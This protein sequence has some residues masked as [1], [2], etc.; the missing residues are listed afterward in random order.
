[1]FK[2]FKSKA[3]D[4][5]YA[6]KLSLT[7][8]RLLVLET[9]FNHD[10][11]VSAYDLKKVIN[12]TGGNLN[13]AT[14]YRILEFWCS[15][16]LVHR[17]NSI[18]KFVCCADPEEKHIHIINCCEKC[19]GLIETCNEMMGLDISFGIN[20]LGLTLVKNSHIEIPVICSDCV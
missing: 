12:K 20:N 14:I 4:R 6:E 15:L 5:C 7:P 10:K 11:P 3:L 18:N 17:I 8:Q 13:I 2:D 1:M 19:D 16:H 9:M